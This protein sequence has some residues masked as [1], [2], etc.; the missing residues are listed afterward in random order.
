MNTDQ[1]NNF[2][3]IA[4][5]FLGSFSEIAVPL[6]NNLNING[7]N[8]LATIP[9]SIVNETVN[10]IKICVIIPGVPKESINIRYS[11]NILTVEGRTSICS[12]EWGHLN[13]KTYKK[14]FD[15]GK[16]YRNDS[17]N[18][19]YVDGVLKIIIDKHNND[20]ININVN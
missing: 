2:Q 3:N 17:I 9:Y 18:T 13:E 7:V 5:Q 12:N 4:N 8:N 15:I 16:G 14:S 20:G 10:N 11:S 1:I 19:E 6:A